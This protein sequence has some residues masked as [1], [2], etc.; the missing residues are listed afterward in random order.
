MEA[1]LT[2]LPLDDVAHLLSREVLRPLLRL[3]R[4][5]L[6]VALEG[7]ELLEAVLQRRHALE[8]LGVARHRHVE[9]PVH[10]V[11]LVAELLALGV[12]AGVSVLEIV[13]LAAEGLLPPPRLG[14]DQT[15]RSVMYSNSTLY[16]YGTMSQWQMRGAW[17]DP[18][19][20]P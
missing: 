3:G 18:A 8:Q 5:L 16:H 7:G 15:L 1:S 13:D 6:A 9:Q 14:L 10:L 11:V 19:P 2:R 12:G 4:L 20:A 17:V